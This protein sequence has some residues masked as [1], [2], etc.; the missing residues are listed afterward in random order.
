MQ[1]SQGRESIPGTGVPF[2]PSD[3]RASPGSP[4][5]LDPFRESRSVGKG[6]SKEPRHQHGP[7]GWVCT[8]L[9]KPRNA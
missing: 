9:V 8:G 4:E 5:N 7:H 6:G 2:S 3:C 1:G